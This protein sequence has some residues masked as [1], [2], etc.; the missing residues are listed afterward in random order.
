MAVALVGAAKVIL[1]ALYDGYQKHE[2]IVA[3]AKQCETSLGKAEELLSM[4]ATL[5][6]RTPKI[7]EARLHLETTVSDLTKYLQE[8]SV[9]SKDTSTKTE[10]KSFAAMNLGAKVA[11]SVVTAA[12]TGIEA[13]LVD[14]V[15]ELS[16]LNSKLLI[17]C[18][19]LSLAIQRMGPPKSTFCTIA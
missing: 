11:S 4:D 3:A 12:K 1:P 9:A 14:R 18:V 13:V 19:D 16:T 5:K 8:M 7:M 2:Q 17:A 15:A 10:E 6:Q